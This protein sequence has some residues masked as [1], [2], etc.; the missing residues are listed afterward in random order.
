VGNVIRRAADKCEDIGHEV[1]WRVKEA[2]FRARVATGTFRGV[3]IDANRKGK[4]TKRATRR[5]L[6][7]HF[8]PGDPEMQIIVDGMSVLTLNHKSDDGRNG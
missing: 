6:G 3:I 1:L 5:L 4:I 7:M 8:T 2:W